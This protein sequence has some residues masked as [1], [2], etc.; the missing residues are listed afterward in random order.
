MRSDLTK[1]IERLEA[2]E[3]TRELWDAINGTLRPRDMMEKDIAETAWYSNWRLIEIAFALNRP[4]ALIPVA[5]SLVPERWD[6]ELQWWKGSDGNTYANA[7]LDHN[8]REQ[9]VGTTCIVRSHAIAL[10]IA[11]LKAREAKP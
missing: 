5:L 11:A 1:L 8:A 6:G 10:A 2:G 4:D 7:T 3:S 9:R